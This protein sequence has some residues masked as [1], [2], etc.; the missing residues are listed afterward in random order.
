MIDASATIC[1]Y[2]FIGISVARNFN[3]QHNFQASSMGVQRK[4][5]LCSILII[6]FVS[7]FNNADRDNPFDPKSDGYQNFGE[8]AGKVYTY[9]EP[10]QPI[11]SVAITL[12]PGG[13]TTVTSTSGAFLLQD[14]APGTYQVTAMR[15]GYAPDTASIQIE[16]NQIASLQFNLDA[17]PRL[18]SLC[19]SSGTEH[20]YYLVEPNRYLV[21]KADVTDPDGLADI[22]SV[23]IVIPTF[24]FKD[25]LALA[26]L[27]GTY[28]VIYQESDLPSQYIEELLG[29][30][31]YLEISD[32]AGARCQFGPYFLAR[33]IEEEPAPTAPASNAQVGEQP[34]FEW[35]EMNPPFPFTFKIEIYQIIANQVIYPPRKTVAQLPSELF[36]Y[37]LNESL[38][39]GQYLWTISIVDKWGNWSRSSPATFQVIK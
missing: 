26:Q 33:I 31:M 35:Q 9:Y 28:Q 37:Q 1:V 24:N 17:L 34:A 21:C 25:T 36:A 29:E 11:S 32:R 14:L 38:E 13:Q 8:L 19:L 2:M 23:A 22:L 10:Y 20:Y 39:V 16:P 30:S 18:D 7:C 6:M 3:E 27:A 5:V 15:E 4:A 12:L